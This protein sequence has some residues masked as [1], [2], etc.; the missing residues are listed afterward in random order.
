MCL[1][2][3]AEATITA[4]VRL[5]VFDVGLLL[6]YCAQPVNSHIE[7]IR[8]DTVAGI[9]ELHI[10]DLSLNNLILLMG[11]A[12]VTLFILSW[13]SILM[14]HRLSRKSILR[15]GHNASRFLSGFFRQVNL[16]QSLPDKKT[17]CIE[18]NADI[19]LIVK[20]HPFVTFVVRVL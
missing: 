12:Y 5:T 4:F 2:L 14:G 11:G 7:I 13:D 19:M 20:T 8:S 15:I 10:I 18:G 3:D 16:K 1:G 6:T 9:F 17:C